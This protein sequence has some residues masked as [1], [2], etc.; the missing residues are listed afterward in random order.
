M[1]I[2]LR[3]EVL[4]QCVVCMKILPNAAMKPSLLKRHL[5]TNQGDNL[6]RD[7]I[8]FQRLGKNVKRQRV[9]KTGQIQQKDIEVVE[10]SY[11]LA[12]LVAKT[13]KAHAIAEFL[14]MPASKILVKRVIGEQSVPKLEIV[15]LCNKTVKRRIDEMSAHVAGQVVA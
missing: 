7:Q 3:G 2:E 5:E 11:E 12:F 15:F 8:Y 4:P 1:A 14:E 6:N 9:D 10:A 13:M